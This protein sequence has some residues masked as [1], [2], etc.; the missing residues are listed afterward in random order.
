MRNPLTLTW[1]I[2]LLGALEGASLILDQSQ[3]HLWGRIGCLLLKAS[4]LAFA[5]VLLLRFLSFRSRKTFESMLDSYNR[6]SGRSWTVSGRGAD[7]WRKFL[8][9]T[10]LLAVSSINLITPLAWGG[11]TFKTSILLDLVLWL[12]ALHWVVR[13]HWLKAQGRRE[14]LKENLDDARSRLKPRSTADT[15]STV[16][17]GSVA[18]D[19][20][21]TAAPTVDSGLSEA[22]RPTPEPAAGMAAGA[23][24]S[25]GTRAWPFLRLFVLAMT[26]TLA[27]GFQR[28]RQAERNFAVTDLKRCLLT[29]L[30]RALD[31]FHGEGRLEGDLD[32]EACLYRH[33]EDVGIGIGFQRG[34][35][36]LWAIEKPG[37]DFFG[38]G[39]TGDQGLMLDGEGRFRDTRRG[40]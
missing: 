7:E 27:I 12:M 18:A 36:L 32:N 40:R 35:L 11:R 34:E 4:Y 23:V 25:A 3:H 21:Q 29:C 39:K 24:P 10:A 16:E 19:H 37:R 33:R 31:R 1:W 20:S 9:Y 2:L 17:A 28:W 26:A 14:K 22:A 6:I 5:C 13:A 8:F 15:P 38:N 30:D